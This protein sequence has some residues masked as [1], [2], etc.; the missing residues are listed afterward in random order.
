MSSRIK[1]LKEAVKNIK[2]LG[3][4]TPSSRFLSKRM[5][6]EINFSNADV[7]VELGPGTGAITK[8]IL[9]NLSPKAI[10]ICF[11]INDNFYQQLHKLEHPQLIILKA[12]A[13]KIVDELKKLQIHQVN[14]IISSLPL[15]IIPDE[16]SSE[17]LER[18]FEVLE[19]N[20]NFIQ[21]QYSLSYF[22]KLKNVYKESISLEF[23]PLNIPPAFIYR[24]KKVV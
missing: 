15:T 24:C 7:I 16:I 10:L 2:T 18:S 13:E 12:S 14:Y 22:R 20:G 19:E 21:Y 11:E 23:E 1:F 17:I 4:V 8:Y 3:T 5:L 9:D 6:R